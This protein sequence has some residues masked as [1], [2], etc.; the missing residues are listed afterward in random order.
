MRPKT[1]QKRADSLARMKSAASARFIPSP[2]G[3]A[4]HR[5]DH[6]LFQVHEARQPHMQVGN[7]LVGLR[8]AALLVQ[9]PHVAAGT[10]DP[11]RAGQDHGPHALVIADLCHNSG[12]FPAHRHV[13]RI[14]RVGAIQG[15]DGDLVAQLVDHGF[16]V[17]AQPGPGPRRAVLAHAV[18]SS[19]PLIQSDTA[20]ILQAI[21]SGIIGFQLVVY[22]SPCQAG[23]SQHHGYA[24]V[25]AFNRRP[26]TAKKPAR[27]KH[28]YHTV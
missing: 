27:Y 11:A 9:P 10:E 2:E 18:L 19:R 28:R 15:D 13:Q 3:G 7:A 24:K 8:R 23:I 4:V 6:R 5:R 22:A 25:A 21:L 16:Q 14:A 12:E 26:L 17:A 20:C 1:W